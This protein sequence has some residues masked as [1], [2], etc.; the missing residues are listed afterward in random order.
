MIEVSTGLAIQLIDCVALVTKVEPKPAGN[1]FVPQV[2]LLRRQVVAQ[3]SGQEILTDHQ[4]SDLFLPERLCQLF[5]AFSVANGA[6]KKSRQLAAVVKIVSLTIIRSPPD[7]E[8]INFGIR[9]CFPVNIAKRR[10]LRERS[11]QI[12][13]AAFRTNQIRPGCRRRDIFP[14]KC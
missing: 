1:E 12:A 2:R 3:K 13:V 6:K 14:Q 7:K 4:M 9:R 5:D 10:I 11:R 8:K